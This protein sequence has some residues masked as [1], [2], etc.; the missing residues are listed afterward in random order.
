[1]R[2]YECRIGRAE[3]KGEDDAMAKIMIASQQMTD[4]QIENVVA[5]L[6]DALRKHRGELGSEPV[7]QALGVE[8]LGMELLA[9]IRKHVEAL[10]NMIVRR[11][12]VDRTRT[13]QAMLDAT[14][15]RQ[16]TNR[17]VV[18]AMPRSEGEEVDVYL[19]KPRPEAYKN[20]FIN[21]DDLEKEY[22]FHG[23]VPADPYSL[24]AVIE[25]DPAF[26][27]KHRNVTHWKDAN[28]KLCYIAFSRWDGER[29]VG[30][31]RDGRV[32]FSEW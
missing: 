21:D 15:R 16:Y 20:G 32:W 26:A 19:F 23:L 12:K 17:K 27:D 6:R 11:V 30:V 18:D 14:G 22:E 5:K 28:G 7:Q 24:A 31:N 1:M 3:A 2:S 10:S 4:G 13:P 9:V 25:A 29:S 8:N